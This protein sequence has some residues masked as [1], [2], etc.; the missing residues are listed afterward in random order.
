MVHLQLTREC[1]LRCYFCGQWGKHGFFS[2][3]S[4]RELNSQD[5]NRIIVSLK[6][7]REETG[8]SPVIMIWG[9]EPLFSPFFSEIS[10]KLKKSRFSLGLITNGVLIDR[11]ADLLRQA[12]DTIYVSVDGPEGIHDRIRGKGV[13]N[14]IKENLKLLKG[15]EA[16]IILMSVITHDN[17]SIAQNIPH[18][19]ASLNPDK[20][21]IQ[22]LIYLT[23][24]EVE[25][26]TCWLKKTFNQSANEIKSWQADNMTVYDALFRE[27]TELV[28]RNIAMGQYPMEVEILSHGENGQC[29]SPWLHLHVAWNGNVLYCTDFYD[30]I[31]GNVRNDDL[32]S[33]FNNPTSEKFRQEV[34]AGHCPTCNHCSWKK[35]QEYNFDDV[36]SP[37]S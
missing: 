6:K 33:I 12:F 29:A 18:I 25:S 15:G 26:Y 23:P 9:G 19:L 24:I 1:N 30:F 22:P 34:A 37:L 27:K 11:H 36:T 4:G 8:I 13:F 32:I 16:K 28:K 10:E 20:V 17:M 7:Y 5:W 14:K 21:I 2:D 35:N 31:A 3:A